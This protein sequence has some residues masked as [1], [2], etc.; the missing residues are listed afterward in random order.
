MYEKR[1]WEEDEIKKAAERPGEQPEEGEA[2]VQTTT[3]GKKVDE[4][5]KDTDD[6]LD[7]LGIDLK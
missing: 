4:K 2:R 7:D 5:K 3:K 1:E 6:V